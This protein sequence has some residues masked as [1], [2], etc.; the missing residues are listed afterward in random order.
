MDEW[1][2]PGWWEAALLTG[3]AF[4]LT[5]FAGWDDFPPVARLRAWLTGEAAE[6]V[7]G[8]EMTTWRRPLV[9]HLL[10]C[11]YCIGFWVSLGTY[12]AWLS[13]PRATLY[14]AAP[15][16][17]STAVGVIARMLDP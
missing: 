8:R 7:A 10:Q 17:L 16:A 1:Q 2:V 12:L 15:L 5:R 14:V 4:R 13:A 6:I 11:A 9:A 3:A